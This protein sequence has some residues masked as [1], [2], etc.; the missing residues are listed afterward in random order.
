MNESP[1][2]NISVTDEQ[3]VGFLASKGYIGGRELRKLATLQE[4]NKVKALKIEVGRLKLE[5]QRIATES[6]R[7]KS[8]ER[9]AL[10][11]LKQTEKALK[12]LTGLVTLEEVALYIGVSHTTVRGYSENKRRA[13]QYG[14]TEL[15]RC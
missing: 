4:N 15:T 6:A 9:Q 2:L 10:F 8:E 12:Q 5:E 7:L 1:A 13:L 11:N 3:I 14:V